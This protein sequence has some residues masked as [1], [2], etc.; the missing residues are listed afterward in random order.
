ML[1]NVSWDKRTANTFTVAHGGHA[2]YIAAGG[3]AV[4]PP[5]YSK[6]TVAGIPAYWQLS[7]PPFTGPFNHRSISSLKSGYVVTLTSMGLDQPEVEQALSQI[8]S[9]L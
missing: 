2:K 9:R 4:P 7:P 6:V 5:Q 3:S 8:L 1:V